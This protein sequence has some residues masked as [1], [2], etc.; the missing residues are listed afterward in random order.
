[1]TS[2]PQS[3]GFTD[4]REEVWDIRQYKL[5]GTI[6]H[7]VYHYIETI[8]IQLFFVWIP[9][10]WSE[11]LYRHSPQVTE[12]VTMLADCSRKKR[13]QLNKKKTHFTIYQLLR[14]RWVMIFYYF[15]FNNQDLQELRHWS[16][17][18]GN[19]SRYSSH[20]DKWRFSGAK[21]PQGMLISTMWCLHPEW[22][23][24]YCYFAVLKC[25]TEMEY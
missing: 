16:E 22:K 15:F 19:L 24:T 23:K 12:Q 7:M 5:T 3:A 25:P 10:A 8:C 11:N 6:Y 21:E 4:V 9:A 2:K 14:H 13:Q 1:M 17:N 18:V 20:M